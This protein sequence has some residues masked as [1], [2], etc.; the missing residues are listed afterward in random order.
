[1]KT[2]TISG[3]LPN[4]DPVLDFPETFKRYNA[5]ALNIAQLLKNRTLR[6]HVD[7]LE[8]YTDDLFQFIGHRR[9]LL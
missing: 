3:M 7:A 5:V 2:F 6:A 8:V 4:S 1:M 9:Y